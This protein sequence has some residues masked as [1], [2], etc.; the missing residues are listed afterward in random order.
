MVNGVCV[1]CKEGGGNPGCAV[2]LCAKEKNVE[3]C[4]LCDSYP[5]KTF[6]KY[7]LGYP[8]LREDNELLIREGMDSWSNLQNERHRKGYTYTDEKR[9]SPVE[10]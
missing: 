4:A 8:M 5:C 1:S 2:R 10:D 9:K 3:M 7:F 6:E